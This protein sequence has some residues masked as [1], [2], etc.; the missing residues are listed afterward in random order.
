MS[1]SSCCLSFLCCCCS[2]KE[3]KVKDSDLPH[4]IPAPGDLSASEEGRVRNIAINTLQRPPNVLTEVLVVDRRTPRLEMDVPAPGILPSSYN[5]V[6]RVRLVPVQS[7]VPLDSQCSAF[8]VPTEQSDFLPN[9]L[10]PQSGTPGSQN[11]PLPY[12]RIRA[13]RP[14]VAQRDPQTNT[15]RERRGEVNRPRVT[16]NTHPHLYLLEPTTPVSQ[17]REEQFHT[18]IT[19]TIFCLSDTDTVFCLSDN[20]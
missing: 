12:P 4:A 2:S 17:R 13:S 14:P 7:P 19:N 8:G 15:Q 18:Q 6:R 1:F 20:E 3:A 9:T 5:R 16:P 10:I 11:D